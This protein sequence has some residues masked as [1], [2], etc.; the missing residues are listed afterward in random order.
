MNHALS[1]ATQK[2]WKMKSDTKIFKYTGSG[3][4]TAFIKML[5]S[6]G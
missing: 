5:T 2:C 3:F 1:V 4:N 6:L